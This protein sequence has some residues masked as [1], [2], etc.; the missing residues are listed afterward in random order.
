VRENE[1]TWRGKVRGMTDSEVAEFLSLGVNMYLAC[2][3]PEGY[4]YAT[5]CW[6]EWR[7]GYFW[8]IP[9]QRSQWAEYLAK[10]PRVSFV[11]EQPKTLGKV[12]GRGTA[13]V[14]E[15]PN[16]GGAWVPI[17]TRMSYRYLGKNGPTYLEST[18]AQPRW[19]FRIRPEM[20]KTWQ[21]VGWAR[22]YWVEDSG[23]PSYEEAHAS[24]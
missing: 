23:G 6:H 21:G 7:D 17:A 18:M 20:I 10:D 14:I 24:V 8:V 5:V 1:E 15:R 12:V 22:H 13:E 9:R 2:V 3:T 19:L 4:P 16:V 11:I